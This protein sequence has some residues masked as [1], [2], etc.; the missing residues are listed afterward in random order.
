MLYKL[1]DFVSPNLLKSVYYAL[2]ES[3]LNYACTVW[4]QNIHTT[5]RLFILQKKALRTL[6]FKQRNT[7][8]NPLFLESE[9]IKFPDKVK[10]ENCLFVS[11]Y[12]HNKLPST[13]N[14][15]FTFSSNSHKYETT[16]A[17]QGNLKVPSVR[18][19][20]YGKSSFTSMAVK[21]WNDLQKQLKENAFNAFMPN[22]VKAVLQGYFINLYKFS[23]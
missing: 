5:N 6:H 16:F 7:H 13:F 19:T 20:S 3:H 9:I 15:W 23:Q 14:K 2:F 8:S 12:F 1:R 4:G 22:K 11:K 21:T 10:I 18:T 17:S